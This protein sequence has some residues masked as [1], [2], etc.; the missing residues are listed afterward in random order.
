MTVFQE[1]LNELN[2]CSEARDWA[3]EMTIE[4][5]VETCERGDWLL[6]V[7]KKINVDDRKLTLAKGLCANT[8]RHLMKD[9]RS[10]LAVD[11]A[12]A[13]GKGEIERD[14]L[15]AAAAS[16]AASYE[17]TAYAAYAAYAASNDSYESAAYASASAAYAASAAAYAASAASDTARKENQMQTANICRDVIGQ[18]IIDRVNGLLN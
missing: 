13:Y 3:S 15:N 12:I 16:D 17:S 10:I 11:A 14:E 7:S 8:V 6:W 9:E 5:V 2:A 4:E 1:L 18:E